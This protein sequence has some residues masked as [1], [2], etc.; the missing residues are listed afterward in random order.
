MIYQIGSGCLD[1]NQAT[2]LLS[3]LPPHTQEHDKLKKALAKT[4]SIVEICLP[5]QN[6]KINTFSD[7]CRLHGGFGASEHFSI[8]EKII[9]KGLPEDKTLLKI[10]TTS[11]RFEHI[12]ALAGDYYGVVGGA[13]SL[14][15]GSQQDKTERFKKAFKTLSQ[16]DH[17]EIRQI[18]FEINTECL[19]VKNSSMPHH[20]Y[21]NQMIEKNLA[22]KEI[23]NDVGQL[24][25]DN[26]DHFSINA[27]DAYSIGHALAIDTA[28]QAGLTKN[29][30]GLKLAYA[31]DA[32]ACH[33]L[34]D[35]FASGHI[36]NQRGELE[37]FLT[38]ELGFSSE[39][40]KPL[41]GLLT[42]AQHEQ[43]GNA[44][45]NVCNKKEEYWIAYGDGHFFSPKN[46]VNREKVIEAT[47]QSVNEIHQAYAQPENK[48]RSI[49]EDLIPKTTPFNL[50]P[51]YSVENEGKSLFIWRGHEK[52]AITSQ[53]DYL[54]KGIGQ[55][56]SYLPQEYIDG[57]LFPFNVELPPVI[58][59]VIIPLTERVT[60]KMWH[61]IGLAT[62]HQSKKDAL[63]IN[64]K[65]D[66]MADTIKGTYDACIEILD[67]LKVLD[68]KV[69]ELKWTSFLQHINMAIETV[70]KIE[71]AYTTKTLGEDQ[72][73][74]LAN[75]IFNA[76]LTLSTIF[77]NGTAEGKVVLDVCT[78][79]LQGDEMSP[80]EIKANVTLWFRQMLSYQMR[81]LSLYASLRIM[82]D[83]LQETRELLSKQA[84][85]CERDVLDQIE[86]NKKWIDE[87][88]IYEEENYIALQIEKNKT[89][90]TFLLR[91]F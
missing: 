26:S 68:S 35:L 78:Q 45:L 39:K 17:N 13:I 33:F 48:V 43:D 46:A 56:L 28:R 89:A 31:L 10:G 90:K 84:K 66:E 7:S 12:I 59:T 73:T 91:T 61:A 9:L 15:G 14:P 4:S 81:A 51:L 20:C 37:T 54:I 3:K 11:I 88:L 36:R 75:E 74:N 24:L 42:G 47:R 50:P 32:F 23:K 69:D 62:Y 72:Q 86:I 70:N 30:E 1:R 63:Q 76:Y 34:T 65:M 19:A 52:I 21:S 16:A 60:G 2:S 64:Q 44:G 55:A 49:I 41:A 29:L 85:E 8:G 80:W 40:A 87:S 27:I 82:K 18:I 5:N 58:K 67:R 71:R 83:G 22:I 53:M 38:E 79:R 25:I 77:S 6:Y 57:F